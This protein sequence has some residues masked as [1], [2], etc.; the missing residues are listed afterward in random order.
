MP[1]STAEIVKTCLDG[2]VF[3]FFV[4]SRGFHVVS[5]VWDVQIPGL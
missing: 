4:F 3:I 2:V 1:S 5:V